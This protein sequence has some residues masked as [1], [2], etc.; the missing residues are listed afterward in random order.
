MTKIVMASEFAKSIED[1]IKS[2]GDLPIIMEFYDGNDNLTLTKIMS[3]G[4][5]FLGDEEVT[6]NC[7]VVSNIIDISE[8]AKLIIK[9][10]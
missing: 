9:V 8:N 3:L 6:E 2:K 5:G 4:L 7:I 1:I 10:E